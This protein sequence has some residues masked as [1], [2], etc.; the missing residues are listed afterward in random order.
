MVLIDELDKA[1]RDTPND[2]LGEIER[3]TFRFDELGFTVEATPKYKPIVVIT[4]NAERNLPDAFLRR[5]VYHHINTPKD[6]QMRIIAASRLGGLDPDSQ[7]LKAA[8]TLFEEVSQRITEKQPGTAEF[9]ALVSFLRA[10]G[11]VPIDEARKASAMR[12][13]NKT[14]SDLRTATDST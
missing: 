13:F 2:L 1:P 5:C 8:W 10:T 9:I 6:A 7:L 3:M 11:G 14:K 12:I 4:S